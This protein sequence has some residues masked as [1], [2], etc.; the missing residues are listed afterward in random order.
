M[1]SFKALKEKYGKKTAERIRDNKKLLELSRDM[2][3]D[4]RP[5]WFKHPDAGEDQ[6]TGFPRIIIWELVIII[7]CV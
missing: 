5:Y 7:I 4:P 3:I 6:A 2:N 1:I